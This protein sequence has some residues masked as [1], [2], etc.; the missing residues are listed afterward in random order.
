MGAAA[1]AGRADS[2]PEAA[3]WDDPARHAD[4]VRQLVQ[5]YDG[6][7]IAATVPSLPV[8]L[9][10]VTRHVP[11]HRDAKARPWSSPPVRVLSWH[12]PNGSPSATRIRQTWEPVLVYV[13]LTRRKHGTGHPVADTL[14]ATTD[15]IGFPGAKP[16]AWTR[17]VLDVLGYDQGTDT[18]DDLFPGS[19][20]VARELSQ[21]VIL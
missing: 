18:V 11:L 13:P 4:L 8:Y 9:D 14:T 15:R 20:A 2:H 7:A 3:E 21:L 17:W 10:A 5:G 1:G 19:G 16:A 6:W 12:T